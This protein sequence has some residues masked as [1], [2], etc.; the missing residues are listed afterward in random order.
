MAEWAVMPLITCEHAAAG[1]PRDCAAIVNIPK[2]VLRTH[3]G[4]DAGAIEIATV[5]A[6]RLGAP[7]LAHRVT[8]LIVDQNRSADRPEVFS[9]YTRDLPRGVR[10]Q[11]LA[12]YHAPFRADVLAEIGVMLG[13]NAGGGGRKGYAKSGGPNGMGV[14]HVSVHSFTPVLRGERRRVDIGVLFDPSRRFESRI[15]ARWMEEL[16]TLEPRLR[17]EPNEPYKGTDDGHTTHLRTR[18]KDRAYA[19]IELEVNQRLVRGDRARLKRLQKHLGESL[20][21][22][23]GEV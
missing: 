13:K 4:F 9:R 14:A 8:R 7:M 19:G 2:S 15:A 16:C 3:R 22:A 23:L 12:R 5:L 18:L 21:R 10:E 20:A 6:K 1:V 17:I 11:M